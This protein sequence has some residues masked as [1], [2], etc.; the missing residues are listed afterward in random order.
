MNE[1]WLIWAIKAFREP[2]LRV[3]AADAELVSTM[4]AI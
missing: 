3:A 2:K 4:E 1:L